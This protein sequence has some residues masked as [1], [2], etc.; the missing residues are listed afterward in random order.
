MHIGKRLLLSVVFLAVP[1][2]SAGQAEEFKK[3]MEEEQ[4]SSEMSRK[5]LTPVTSFGYI[6]ANRYRSGRDKREG[7]SSDYWNIDEEMSSFLRLRFKNHF[8]NFPYKFVGTFG[9]GTNP[10]IGRL[11]CYIWLHGDSYPIAYHV[12]CYLGAGKKSRVLHD[13]TLGITSEDRAN[14]DIQEALDRIVS[15]FARIFFRA[16]GAP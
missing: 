12:E 15:K 13:A 9:S 16:R 7:Q 10:E 2:L 4:L 5:Y 6:Y 1:A 14:N 11:Q 3:A 8:A